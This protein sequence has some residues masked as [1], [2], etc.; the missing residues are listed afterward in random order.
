MSE[1]RRFIVPPGLLTGR[2]VTLDGELHRHMV[3]VLRLKEGDA[4]ILCNGAGQEYHSIIESIGKRSLALEIT[5]IH[6]VAADLPASP[7]ITLIQGIPKGD[8]FD[9]VIQ[10]A[11]ELGVSS[12]VAFPAD[13]SVIKISSGQIAN[14]IARW[15]KIALEAARQSERISVPEI[16]LT[17][18]LGTSLRD[19]TQT[20]KLLLSER[21]RDSHLRE[22]LSGKKVPDS[23]AL[24]VGPE[25]GFSPEEV[26]SAIQNGFTPVSLGPRI[27]RTETASLVM[28]SIIQ[29]QWGDIG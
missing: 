13:R 28:L 15:Q 11:T 26:E 16:S 12:I 8:K 29:Y 24:L 27:L 14:R 7:S 2:H 22:I 9:L 25:G 6:A 21:E 3:R 10:K 20:V 23:A 1:P 18:D 4:L 19:A 5:G 17:R